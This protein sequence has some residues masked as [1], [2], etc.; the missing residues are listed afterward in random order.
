M[1]IEQ[2]IETKIRQ[3]FH[4]V[5]LEVHNES[6]MHNVPPGSESHFKLILVSTTFDGLR[7]VQRHQRVYQVLAEEMSAS[8]HA[9]ALHTYTPTEWEAIES[10]P[11]S[12]NCLGGKKVL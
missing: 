6:H 9:L 4:V 2:Q 5:H 11:N 3:A 10:T 12:P 8:V 7:S 1:S